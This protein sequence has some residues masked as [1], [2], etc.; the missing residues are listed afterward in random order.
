MSET[1]GICT[2]CGAVVTYAAGQI[3]GATITRGRMLDQCEGEIVPQPT[4]PAEGETAA[5]DPEMPAQELRLHMGE[6]T[7][8]ELRV[9]RAAI[10]WANSRWLTRQLAEAEA[11]VMALPAGVR[12]SDPRWQDMQ[13]RRAAEG[14]SAVLA[15]MEKAAR[16]FPTWP[17]RGTDAAAIV[18]EECGELQRAVLQATYEGGGLEAVRD[19]AIQTAAMA[20][21]F[22][23]N[24]PD[25][26]FERGEQVAKRVAA[27][28]DAPK[29]CPECGASGTHPL[30]WRNVEGYPCCSRCG[31]VTSVQ[32]ISGLLTNLR[33][34]SPAHD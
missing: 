4:P 30:T 17:I 8:K 3:C 26:R 28:S 21:Q 20:L 12:E 5:L 7:A 31:A 1:R 9:A 32:P 27:R 6:L 15:E 14:L 16:K 2:S 18:A 25:T 23:L 24:L 29:R 10:R 34:R 19:E 13:Q 11:H 33:G 22:L